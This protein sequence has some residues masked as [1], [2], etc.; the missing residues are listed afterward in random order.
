MNPMK[1]K[2]LIRLSFVMLLTAFSSAFSQASI[3]IGLGPAFPTGQFAVDDPWDSRAGLAGPGLGLSV[4]YLYQIP[5]SSLG[6]FASADVFANLTSQD[7]IDAWETFNPNAEI[8]LPKALNWPLSAG[9]SYIL[10]TDKKFSLYG[11]A[12][13]AASFL[14]YTGLQA[15][16]PGYPDY[17]EEYK[18][19]SALGYVLA[20]GIAGK[21]L[22]LEVTYMELGR[23]KISGTWKEASY[24]GDLPAVKKEIGLIAIKLGWQVW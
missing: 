18:V 13:V 21:K 16:E 1:K 15:K 10:K 19:S 3:S 4:C 14:K 23:H 12:G 22:S 6:L 17:S 11:K 7:A 2:T 9:L 8:T 24:S 20:A 5:E